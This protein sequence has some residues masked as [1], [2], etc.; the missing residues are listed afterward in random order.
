MPIANGLSLPNPL[1]NGTTGDAIPVMADFNYLLSALNRAMLDGGTGVVNAQAAKISNLANG[2]SPNDAVNLSQLGAYALLVGAAFTGGI[3]GTTLGLSSTLNVTGASTLAAL[4]ASGLITG[5][6]GFSGTTL[7]LSGAATVGGNLTLTANAAKF[8]FIDANGG[9]P[10]LICQADNHLVLYGTDAGGAARAL[11]S[12]IMH[13]S[14]SAINFAVATMGLT[15]S[16]GDNSTNLAT[17]AFVATVLG[18]YAPLA[19]PALTGTPTAPTPT[20]GDNSTKIA[21]TA[22]LASALGSYALLA[23]PAFT[24]TP[25]APTA[26]FGTS[27]TQLATTAFVI[28]AKSPNVQSVASA[29]TVTPTFANDLVDITAQAVAMTLAN[30]TGTAVNGWGMVIRIKDNGTPQTIAYGTQYAAIGVA[31]PTTTVAGKVLILGM[32]YNSTLTRWELVSV[33]EE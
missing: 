23:S 33:A 10:Y 22:F 9:N 31:K 32:I 12:V 30:P 26:A 21:T 11:F 6:A 13:S 1:S 27:S 7:A 3:T 5:S 8:Q 19:S 14:T 25:A 18:S 16:P 17:T 15:P 20:G 2:V 29:A 4:T 28:G 24:G